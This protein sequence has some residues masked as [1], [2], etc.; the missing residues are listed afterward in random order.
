MRKK[1]VSEHLRLSVFLFLVMT[2]LY[3][4]TIPGLISNF[5]SYNIA[6]KIIFPISLLIFFPIVLFRLFC[7]FY[8]IKLLFFPPKS[9]FID[10][11]IEVWKLVKS[12]KMSLRKKDWA[13]DEKFN[14][15]YC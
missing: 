6:W 2:I 8:D 4:L 1:D 9:I 7:I 12:L 3:V 5:H 13:V 10:G 15:R 11:D 14:L